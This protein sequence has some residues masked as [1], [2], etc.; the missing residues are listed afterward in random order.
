LPAGLITNARPQKYFEKTFSDG[1]PD[2]MQA[3]FLG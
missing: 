2:A 3:N 1:F